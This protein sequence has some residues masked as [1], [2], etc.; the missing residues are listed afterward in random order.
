VLEG[1]KG[2]ALEVPGELVAQWA[3]KPVAFRP[4]RRGIPVSFRVGKL[5]FE[6]H[7]VARA[8]RHW[9]LLDDEALGVLQVEP[10]ARLRVVIA[11]R[12]G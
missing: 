11:L 9:L 3:A 1:H 12:A 7:V 5:A 10:G 4:G 2:C 8:R 6:S